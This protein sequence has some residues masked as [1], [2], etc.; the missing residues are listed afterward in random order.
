MHLPQQ[1]QRQMLFRVVL[2][3]ANQSPT[4]FIGLCPL[5]HAG[6]KILEASPFSKEKGIELSSLETPFFLS[7][8]F[9][10]YGCRILQCLPLTVFPYYFQKLLKSLVSSVYSNNETVVPFSFHLLASLKQLSSP[11]FVFLL[12]SCL[13]KISFLPHLNHYFNLS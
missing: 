10:F 5:S 8:L 1:W 7:F 2:F 13:F 3:S 6:T 12:L 9:N 4:E 11:V